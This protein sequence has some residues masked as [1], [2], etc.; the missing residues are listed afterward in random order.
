MDIHHDT[1]FK[2]ILEDDS[3]SWAFGTYIFFCLGKGVG[4]WL[5]V[6]PFIH[7]FH[8]THSTFTSALCFRLGLIKPLASS[9]FTCECA[10]GLDTSN[11][12][13][14]RYLFGSQWIVT[15]DAIQNVIYVFV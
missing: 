9:F 8:I 3:I 1:S 13:L 11:M 7:L 10:H 6:K 5:V 12:H 4:L 15:H 2:S 14:V